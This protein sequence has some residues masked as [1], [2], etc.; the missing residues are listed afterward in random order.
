MTEDR[1]KIGCTACGGRLG[2]PAS[3]LGKFLKCPRCNETFYAMELPRSGS[4][5]VGTA[6]ARSGPGGDS[7]GQDSNWSVG[8]SS[9]QMIQLDI[10]QAFR[11]RKA[12]ADESKGAGADAELIRGGIFSGVGALVAALLWGAAAG[13]SG[14]FLG[15]MAWLVGGAAGG[16]MLLG[17]RRRTT[18]AGGAAAA[19][20]LAG[21]LIGKALV[22]E[23]VVLAPIRAELQG[24]ALPS[25]IWTGAF[26]TTFG[27]LDA[28]FFLMTVITAYIVAAGTGKD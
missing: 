18:Q 23:W 12:D 6:A 7:G 9:S 5:A 8:L 3:A 22:T 19:I 10:R 24:M 2:V 20:G 14:Q 13:L 27:W 21:Y 11:K 25:G 28:V 16:G 26:K 1:V 15:W 4:A 17:Y